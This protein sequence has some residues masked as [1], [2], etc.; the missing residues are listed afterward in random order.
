MRSVASGCSPHLL[1]LRLRH[2]L[3]RRPWTPL[4]RLPR[5]SNGGL[6]ALAALPAIALLKNAAGAEKGGETRGSFFRSTPKRISPPV[7]PRPAVAVKAKPPASRKPDKAERP[8]AVPKPSPTKATPS[9]SR[10][11]AGSTSAAVRPGSTA[12]GGL[13][14]F[15]PRLVPE[16]V[17]Y[18]GWEGI[19]GQ[20]WVVVPVHLREMISGKI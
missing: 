3:S 15:C 4:P 9:S 2:V 10:T 8:A 1:S 12:Q 5:L 18:G 16:Q 6:L 19:R 20:Y 14:S 7:S 13:E 11:A 17:C